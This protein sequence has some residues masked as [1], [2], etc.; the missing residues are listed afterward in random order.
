M[1]N[2]SVTIFERGWIFRYRLPAQMPA[3]KVAVM[4]HGWTGDENSME[5]FARG[6]P[7]NCLQL[8]PRGPV[9]APDG[10]YGWTAV[11]GVENSQMSDFVPAADQLLKEI[12]AH[13]ADWKMANSHFSITGFSQGAA[14]AYVLT[15]LYP[16]RIERMAALAGFMP[17]LPAALDLSGLQS[18]PIYI[19]HGTRDDTIPV[20]EARKAARLLVD[21]GA[22]VDYCENS[23]GHKLPTSCFTKLHDFLQA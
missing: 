15:V 23:A 6:L 4:I 16:Q 12:D 9:S 1:A 7:A 22:D 3:Q 5:I 2:E 10:G 19:A 13:L 18:K 8:F 20:E 11:R 21:I 14:M 17:A